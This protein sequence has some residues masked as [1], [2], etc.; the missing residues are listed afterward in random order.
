MFVRWLPLSPL[1]NYN[2]I[3]KLTLLPGSLL[4]HCQVQTWSI[5]GM[6]SLAG[7]VSSL[8]ICFLPSTGNLIGRLVFVGSCCG[9][10]GCAFQRILE[11]Q[12]GTDMHIPT[13]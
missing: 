13:T 9:V 3:K 5:V 1:F 10:T 8:C 12:R 6:A 11:I 7:V 4:A 2:N